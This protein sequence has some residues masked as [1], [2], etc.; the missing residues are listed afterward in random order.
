MTDA[1]NQKNTDILR[2]QVVDYLHIH[3]YND[4]LESKPTHCSW[5]SIIKGK[6]LLNKEEIKIFTDLY[7]NAIVGGVEDFTILEIQQ[8]Y[9]PIIIDIDLKIPLDNFKQGTRLYDSKMI[10]NVINNYIKIINEYLEVPDNINICLFEK[11]NPTE[12][13]DT[14]KDGFH[15]YIPDLITSTTIRH[16]IRDKVVKL[17]LNDNIF[18]KFTEIPDKIIDKAVVSSNGWLLPGSRKPGGQV[19]E[20]TKIYNK[21]LQ[22]IH[23]QN[24]IAIAYNYEKI[25]KYFS[26]NIGK[27]NLKK[28]ATIVNDSWTESEINAEIKKN[29]LNL[30]IKDNDNFFHNTK[31][32]EEIINQACAYMDMLYDHRFDNYEDWRNIGLAAHNT[33][34]SLLYKW[35]EKSKKC[36]GKYKEGCCEQYWK[37]FK[38]P[39]SGNLL[40]IRSLAYW[41][42]QDNPKEFEAYNKTF[43]KSKLRDSLDNN[44]YSLAIAFK[45]KYG[46]RFVCTSQKSN[47]WYEYKNHKW[48][49]IEDAYTMRILFSEEFANEY[50]DELRETTINITKVQGYEKDNLQN[51]LNILSKI[52][53]K[54]RNFDFKNKLINEAKSIFYDRNFYDKLD[55]NLHLMGFNNGVYDAIKGEFRDGMYDDYISLCTKHDYRPYSDHMPYKKDIDTFFHQV[56]PDDD[57]CEFLLTAFSTCI[58]GDTKEEKL[59]ILTGSGSNSKSVTIELM[60]LALGDYFMSCPITIITRKRGSSNETSPEKVRMK[61]RRLGVFQETDDGERLNVGVMKE[62]TGGDKILVRDL[63]K[64][65]KEMIEFKPQIKYFL[66]CNTLPEVPSNDDGTWRRLRVIDFKSKFTDNPTKPNEYKIN[67]NLKHEIK[68]WAPYLLSY[69]IHIYN[70]KYKNINYLKEPKEVLASTNRYKMENDYYT[71]YFMEKLVVTTDTKN[72]IARDNLY[73]DF[74]NW[75]KSGYDFKIVPKKPEFE[76]AI[77]KLI[78]EPTSRGYNKIIFANKIEELLQNND[79]L[80]ILDQ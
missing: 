6:F 9:S 31:D 3:R 24:D 17:Y 36:E 46:D 13:E 34:D 65:S 32:K 33:D 25:I 30:N 43:F 52:T 11:K 74:K 72:T 15:I 66:I 49:Y 77:N 29:N 40:T 59:Y 45:A 79:N 53:E 62:F 73:N 20:L 61:G 12:S 63:F 4:E 78:G 64:G 47:E 10:K 22:V 69:M 75:Y 28:Y 55:S 60:G 27:R 68:K 48:E 76:K 54:L 8:D 67:T 18:E 7:I 58:T 57:V 71:E 50:Y 19:Y 44:T 2:K 38:S 39:S 37:T 1:K 41:A 14:C 35:I 80:S 23:R 26:L 21:E 42:K 51:K 70:T 56:I 16:L 5:G